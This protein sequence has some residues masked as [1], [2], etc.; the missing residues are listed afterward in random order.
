MKN[1]FVIIILLLSFYVQII[2]LPVSI[3]LVGNVDEPGVYILDSSNRVSQAIQ[4][5]ELGIAPDSASLLTSNKLSQMTE[6]EIDT[7]LLE[8]QKIA[9]ATRNKQKYETNLEE[10]DATEEED[11]KAKDISKRR[12]I[13]IRDG[14]AQ[15]LNLQ[16]FYLTG[17]LTNNPYL[18]ND[19]IIKLL[20]IESSVKLTGEVNREGEYELT[21]GEKLSD[22]IEFGQGLTQDAD[23]SNI[24]VERYNQTTGE[25]SALMVNYEAVLANHNSP[26]NIV[27]SHNDLVKV[28]AKPYLNKRKS[29]EVKG[30]VKYPGE[31]SIDENSTL[32][33]VLESA[34][35]PLSSADLNFAILIDK[36]LYESFDPDLERLLATNSPLLSISE[37]SYIQTKLREISGKHYLNIKEL[38]ET[39]DEKYDRKLKSGD[40]IYIKEPILLV[41]VSGAV[42]NAGL[43]PWEEGKTLSQYIK[44]SG[45]YIPSAFKSKVRVIRYNTNVWVKA[46]NKTVINPGDEIF[47][48]EVQDK[49]LWDYVSES[50]S[51]T[52]QIITI[53]LGV[54]TL[55]K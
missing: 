9:L 29:V 17:D 32:L 43:Q 19:D 39:K 49:T 23:L 40:I 55:T 44:S 33:S 10:E 18:Q 6:L 42:Q 8:K 16:A 47:V 37:Y 52:A 30:L 31:Y 38:W 50:L 25:L 27:L 12:V 11:Y 5:I 53:V 14:V 36:S 41:N 21:E 3:S 48:P 45:G 34:G 35:G 20:P 22:L 7:S 26:E 51:V 4:L 15:E 1:K 2:A 24:R 13:L 28:F 54:H 46:N